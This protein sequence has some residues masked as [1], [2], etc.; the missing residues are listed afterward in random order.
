MY[1]TSKP[2]DSPSAMLSGRLSSEY[3][4]IRFLIV[5]AGRRLFPGQ[6]GVDLWALT[7]GVLRRT[8]SVQK[9][10]QSVV[11][12]ESRKPEA[13]TIKLVSNIPRYLHWPE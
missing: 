8:P 7:D 6:N 12:W 2:G 10:R 5:T 9:L 4:P 1:S 11:R 3:Q 13:D